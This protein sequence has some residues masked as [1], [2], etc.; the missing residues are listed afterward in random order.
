MIIAVVMTWRIL[1][2]VVLTTVTSAQ[3]CYGAAMGSEA[4]VQR[5]P[6]AGSVR[7]RSV[8]HEPVAPTR[9]GS[10]TIRPDQTSTRG[11]LHILSRVL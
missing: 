6:S 10:L 9:R 2:F 1:Y 4:V 7:L 8:E 5:P 11:K 3:L